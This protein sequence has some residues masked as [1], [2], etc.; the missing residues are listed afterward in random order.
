MRSLSVVRVLA[1]AD[2]MAAAAV[3][4]PGGSWRLRFIWRQAHQQ[5]RL[6]R[7]ALLG[8]QP[9]IAHHRGLKVNWALCLELAAAQGAAATK[10]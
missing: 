8:G 10:R 7:A 2:S 1:V 5:S 3:V 9:A 6:A 4:V